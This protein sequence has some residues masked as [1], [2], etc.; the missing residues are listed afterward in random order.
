MN[1]LKLF[2]FLLRTLFWIFRQG[3][4]ISAL[5]GLIVAGFC[6]S[7]ADSPVFHFVWVI[8]ALEANRSR[9]GH[10]I[11]ISV[12]KC[13]L[14]WMSNQIW[15]AH[16][17]VLRIL[18]IIIHSKGIHLRRRIISRRTVC[19]SKS[20][21]LHKSLWWFTQILVANYRT[22][23]IRHVKARIGWDR[24]LYGPKEWIL[25][26][27]LLIT[28]IFLCMHIF[29]TEESHLL[30]WWWCSRDRT[31]SKIGV[32]IHGKVILHDDMRMHDHFRF[33]IA[34]LWCSITF[35]SE[36]ALCTGV[37]RRPW[38]YIKI[39]LSWQF[40]LFLIF[41][42]R[43]RSIWRLGILSGFSLISVLLAFLLTSIVRRSSNIGAACAN[44]VIFGRLA[45][46]CAATGIVSTTIY[47]RTASI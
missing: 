29:P 10:G 27:R 24:G 39:G 4:L 17:E 1:R 11:L 15:S 2:S 22:W 12:V 6:Y 14:K 43:I 13:A 25:I 3:I 8:H 41:A 16:W 33:W 20:R 30:H 46:I 9:L 5:F 7:P 31:I 45:R 21:M 28:K 19:T 38:R 42:W 47:G 35:A 34:V 26:G 37:N 44:S 36:Q 32:G 18:L 23:R 40:V